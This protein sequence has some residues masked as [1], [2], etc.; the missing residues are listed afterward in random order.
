MIYTLITQ[1]VDSD[2]SP[3]EIAEIALFASQGVAQQHAQL[4]AQQAR[5]YTDALVWV[6]SDECVDAVEST[7][8]EGLLFVIAER[9][10]QS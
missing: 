9:S 4:T 5:D 2:D 7:D 6:I 10:V 8:C 3:L 1:V